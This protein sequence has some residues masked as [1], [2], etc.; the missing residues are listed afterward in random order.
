VLHF[1]VII[2][3]K[4]ITFIM[5]GRFVNSVAVHRLRKRLACFGQKSKRLWGEKRLWR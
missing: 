3:I 2:I 5:K 1:S 4:Y